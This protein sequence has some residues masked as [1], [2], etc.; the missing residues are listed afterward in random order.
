MVIK[1][2]G[3]GVLAIIGGVLMVISGYST[4]G[5]FFIALGF[6]AN[7]IPSFLPPAPASI[8]LLVI[9]VI[10]ILIALGGVTVLLGGV[11]LFYRHVRT[12]RVLILLGG[13]AGLLGLLISFG[14]SAL[15]LGLSPALGYAPYWVGLA[16]AVAARALAKRA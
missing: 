11:S 13:G 5:V 14:Y 3:S 2:W 9:F 16:M 8:A 7:E 1:L 4:R 12:G 10:E 6:A 15:R